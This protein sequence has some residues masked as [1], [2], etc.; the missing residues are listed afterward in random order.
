MEIHEINQT[1]LLC[2]DLVTPN[3]VQDHWKWHKMVEVYRA[4]KHGMYERIWLKKTT[5][6]VPR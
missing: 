6:N 3:Q 5:R 4:N 1:G 2:A